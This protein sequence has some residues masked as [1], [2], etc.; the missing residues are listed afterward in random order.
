MDGLSWAYYETRFERDFYRKMGT[1]FQAFFCEIMKRGHPGDFTFPAPWGT[2]GDLKNDGFLK[3]ERTLFQA[4]APERM[5]EKKTVDKIEK[6]FNGALKHW[7]GRFDKWVFVHNRRS[8]LPPKAVSKI[9]ELNEA[10]PDIEVCEWGCPEVHQRLSKLSPPDLLSLFGEV[11][12][13]RTSRRVSFNKLRK[14]ISSLSRQKPSP[15]QDLS[16][17]SSEKLDANGLSD[18]VRVLLKAGMSLSAQVGRLFKQHYDPNLGDEIAQAFKEEYKRLRKT[19]DDPDQIFQGLQE[20]V[21]GLARGEPEYEVTVLAI[22]AYFFEQCDI[23][24]NPP[25][26]GTS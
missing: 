24:E 13:R 22:L 20:F 19:E 21:G 2:E 1:E 4:Y 11:P 26:E 23:F 7:K 8:G 6:D 16:P 3:S 25:T 5:E 17:P 12:S 15:D 14:I 18:K 10:Q 9:I